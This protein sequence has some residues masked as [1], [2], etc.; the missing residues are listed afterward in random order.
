MSNSAFVSHVV[1]QTQ[2]NIDFLQAQGYLTIEEV[3]IIRSKLAAA[4]VKASDK[5]ADSPLS[6]PQPH[7]QVS[8]YQPHPPQPPHLPQP[9]QPIPS[10]PKARALWPYNE[11]KKVCLLARSSIVWLLTLTRKEPNDL[12]ISVGD[13]IDI[14]EETN[15][16]WWTGRNKGSQGLF[17]STYVQKIPPEPSLQHQQEKM[18]GAPGYTNYGNQPPPQQPVYPINNPP[19]VNSVGLQPDEGQDKKKKKYGQLKNTVRF[20]P[21]PS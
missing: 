7:N 12:T 14:V 1:S 4:T 17:P 16:D 11:D 5:S 6:F 8:T 20:V 15:P 10:Y 21:L 13:V 9:P 2:A 19:V 3:T 18:Y